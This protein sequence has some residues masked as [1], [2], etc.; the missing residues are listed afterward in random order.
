MQSHVDSEYKT[1]VAGYERGKQTD[2]SAI[3]GVRNDTSPAR[4]IAN[5]VP[6]IVTDPMALSRGYPQQPTVAYG[7]NVYSPI[8]PAAYGSN[9]YGS[10]GTAQPGVIGSNVLMQNA[11]PVYNQ[12]AFGNNTY[13][14][15][16]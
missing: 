13:S 7:S 5:N 1:T 9:A 2:D 8:A 4:K 12:P 10:L 15:I 6:V 14:P 16:R 3:F 11:S